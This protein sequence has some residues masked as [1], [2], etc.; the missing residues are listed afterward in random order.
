MYKS[1]LTGEPV[2]DEPSLPSEIIDEEAEKSA[3]SAAGL[4]AWQNRRKVRPEGGLASNMQGCLLL[5]SMI[6]LGHGANEV[7]IDRYVFFILFG[8]LL[9]IHTFSLLSQPLDVLITYAKSPISSHLLDSFFNSQAVATK[10]KRR[11]QNLLFPTSTKY[12][13]TYLTLAKD[14]LGSRV[15]DTIWA[16]SDGYMREKIAKSLIPHK[17][18]LGND[19]YGRWFGKKLELHLLERRPDEWREKVDRKSV[20]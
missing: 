14:K 5:Q 7:V 11:F 6:G 2:D 19:E 17:I 10:H 1:I 8:R 3:A 9:L 13:N 12:G 18:D 4:L 15:I 16:V 20:V